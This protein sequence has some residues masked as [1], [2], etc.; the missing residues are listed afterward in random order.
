M[1][2]VFQPDFECF[3]SLVIIFSNLLSNV[4]EPNV[5]LQFCVSNGYIL[6]TIS[7]ELLNVAGD[8]HKFTPSLF[9]TT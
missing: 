1:L 4:H 7:Q 2:F 6:M 3:L 5:N 9:T 8:I